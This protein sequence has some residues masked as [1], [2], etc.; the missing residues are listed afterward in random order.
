MRIIEGLKKV[1]DL[2]RKIGDLKI[3]IQE[4]C[5]DMDIDTP[6][7][8]TEADQREMIKSWL[9]SIHDSVKEIMRLRIA[10]Q[11]T[12]LATNV[13]ITISGKDVTHSIAEWIHRRRDL[14]ENEKTAWLCLSSKGLRPK[15]FYNDPKKTEESIQLSKP[16]LYFDM[17]EKNNRVEEFASEP[18]LI[19]GKLEV[20]NAET[21]L[22]EN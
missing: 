19:D 20:I 18:S 16:R 8:K 13:T 6:V 4:H 15:N 17:A 3:K 11:R 22:I 21:D 2:Q 14:A 1:Q 12:N 5:A 10:I 9:Q 7:F